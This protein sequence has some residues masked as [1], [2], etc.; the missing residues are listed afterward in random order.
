MANFDFIDSLT[1][2]GRTLAAAG[3]PEAV[4][5]EGDA[6][7]DITEIAKACR[8]TL[9]AEIVKIDDFIRMAEAL[10]KYSQGLDRSQATDADG[11][12]PSVLLPDPEPDATSGRDDVTAR[13][14]VAVTATTVEKIDTAEREVLN[15]FTDCY[16]ADDEELTSTTDRKSLGPHLFVIDEQPSVNADESPLIDQQSS[17]TG[18]ENVHVGKRLRQRRWMMGMSKRQLG[19]IVGVKSDQ[20]GKIE[21]DEAHLS[22]SS[23]W[24]IAAALNVPV[25]YFFEDLDGQAVD[26]GEARGDILTDEE[27]LEM[28][29][30]APNVRSA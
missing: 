29:G 11:A 13:D 17:D 1:Y 7:M 9:A 30:A 20:I 23:M 12:A 14:S 28:V 3:L 18:L 6:T 10:K 5:V 25:S 8:V 16:P 22:A 27:A 26:T 19:D 21:A 24:D 4:G 2:S 15:L